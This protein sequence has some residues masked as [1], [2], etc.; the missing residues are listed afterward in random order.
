MVTLPFLGSILRGG[1]LMWLSVVVSET[2]GV[3]E[4]VAVFLGLSA[5]SAGERASV[6]PPADCTVSAVSAA[7][8]AF[9]QRKRSAVQLY[10]SYL[11]CLELGSPSGSCWGEG[12]RLPTPS[13]AVRS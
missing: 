8:L 10:R 2:E 9:G 1:S 4:T 11:P 3:L 7:R 12:S 5:S 6:L 13:S